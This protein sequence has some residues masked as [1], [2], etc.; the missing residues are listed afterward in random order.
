MFESKEEFTA[1]AKKYFPFLG[2]PNQF[3]TDKQLFDF[4][5]ALKDA[6][7]PYK[8]YKFD[9]NTGT[10]KFS[11]LHSFKGWEMHT[12]FFQFDKGDDA[13]FEFFKHQHSNQDV[14]EKFVNSEIVYTGLTR[15][16]NNLNIINIKNMK[17]HPFFESQ[18]EQY[19]VMF[20]KTGLSPE[21]HPGALSS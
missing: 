17:Y 5:M 11:S 15:A 21:K 2:I 20:F 18:V 10:I 16:R 1:I 4:K 7:R 3:P 14:N 6:R 19:L 13:E 9:L 8:L 12:V